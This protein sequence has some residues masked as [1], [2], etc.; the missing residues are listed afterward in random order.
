MSQRGL[1]RFPRDD[2][3]IHTVG[4]LRTGMDSDS[5]TRVPQSRV[6][7][8]LVAAKNVPVAFKCRE[9]RIPVRFS[10][11]GSNTP[12]KNHVRRAWAYICRRGTVLKS[13]QKTTWIQG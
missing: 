9:P 3:R 4:P 8:A 1:H 10:H 11:L 13:E 5:Q 12:G 2:N 6:A 7:K